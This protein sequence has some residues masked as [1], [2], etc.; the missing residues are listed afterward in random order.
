M[1]KF[2]CIVVFLWLKL[3]LVSG[4]IIKGNRGRVPLKAVVLNVAVPGVIYATA[5]GSLKHHHVVIPECR[6]LSK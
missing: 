4:K 6:V 1:K 2:I 5:H 3:S